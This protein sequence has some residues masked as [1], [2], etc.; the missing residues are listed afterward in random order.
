MNMQTS[1]R[2]G[3][4]V[5]N[6]GVVGG[7]LVVGGIITAKALKGLPRDLTVPFCPLQASIVRT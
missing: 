2:A 5:R 1:S 3:N 7:S 4:R 6:L